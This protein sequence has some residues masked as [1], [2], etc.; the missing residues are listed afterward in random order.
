MG[1]SD[2]KPIDEMWC[3][4]VKMGSVGAGSAAEGCV[5]W[6]YGECRYFVRAVM[7]L[8]GSSLTTR[9]T[10][11]SLVTVIWFVIPVVSL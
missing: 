1:G 5:G 7:N 9:V 8:G 11:Q 10:T 2:E 6:I 4:R 3:E